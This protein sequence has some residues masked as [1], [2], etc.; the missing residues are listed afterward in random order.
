VEPGQYEMI[1]DS[2]KWHTDRII[3]VF[4]YLLDHVFLNPSLKSESLY[5]S[6][7]ILAECINKAEGGCIAGPLLRKKHSIHFQR[8]PVSAD[9]RTHQSKIN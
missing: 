2:K 6:F 8:E 5:I 7:V 4:L 1:K 9:S 3:L